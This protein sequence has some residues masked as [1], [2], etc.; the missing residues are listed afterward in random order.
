MITFLLGL[1]GYED[2]K[3]LNMIGTKNL[4]YL[5]YLLGYNIRL[6]RSFNSLP[7]GIYIFCGEQ[8][9]GKT[10]S[11]VRFAYVLKNHLKYD[12][13]YSNMT[14]DGFQLF[15]KLDS[16]TYVRKSIIVCDEMGIVQNSKSSKD[17]NA[18]LLRFSAQNRKNQRIVLTS[19]QQVYMIQKDL[20]TQCRVL[21]DCAKVGPLVLNRYY[22]PIVDLDG[23]ID[24]S[25]LLKLDFFIAT[26]RLYNLYDT[27]EVIS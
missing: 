19:S 7:Y 6:N 12:H 1:F 20:R 15:N 9:S 11:L 5:P 21:I 17:V 8:G 16:L 24:K 3:I 13:F 2:K 10:L 18:D 25:K 27:C 4:F 22:K 26:K 23:N 14:L